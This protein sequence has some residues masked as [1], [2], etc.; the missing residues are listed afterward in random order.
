ME[1]LIPK[2]LPIITPSSGSQWFNLALLWYFLGGPCFWGGFRPPRLTNSLMVS[3]NFDDI[4]PPLPFLSVIF[5][6]HSSFFLSRFLHLFVQ[7]HLSV[8]QV[9]TS[10]FWPL[11]SLLT[12]LSFFI[13]SKKKLYQNTIK[14]SAPLS[15]SRMSKK[16][17][18][19]S[20]FFLRHFLLNFYAFYNCY[21]SSSTFSFKR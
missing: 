6:Y 9:T 4:H 7:L 15:F 21:Q 2:S 10:D 3:L 8:R 11:T 17:R 16:S 12:A 14:G 1:W 18:N 5:F 13:N 20:L 19:H